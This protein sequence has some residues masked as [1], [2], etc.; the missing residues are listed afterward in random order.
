MIANSGSLRG[1]NKYG[2]AYNG[3]GRAQMTGL[4]AYGD[5]GGGFVRARLHRFQLLQPAA[6]ST[7]TR[8]TAT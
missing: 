4:I 8:A 2:F 7:P 1:S 5:L 3:P 6:S